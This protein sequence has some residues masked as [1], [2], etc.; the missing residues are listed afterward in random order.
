M[1]SL[2]WFF[3]ADIWYSIKIFILDFIWRLLITSQL[4]VIY[5]F[6]KT[7]GLFQWLSGNQ[8]F[9]IIFTENQNNFNR[10]D[11]FYFNRENLPLIFI[12]FCIVAFTLTSII[13]IIHLIIIQFSEGGSFRQKLAISIKNSV[14]AFILIIFIPIFFWFLN[15]FTFLLADLVNKIS[16]FNK[17]QNVSI[18]QILYSVGAYKRVNLWNWTTEFEP[19]EDIENWNLLIQFFACL[20]FLIVCFYLALALVQRLFE[21]FFLFLISP[22]IISMI[23]IDN[24]RRFFIW[25]DL[26]IAKFISSFITNLTFVVFLNIL[27][28]LFFSLPDKIGD[29][30]FRQIIIFIFLVGCSFSAIR[31]QN[32]SSQLLGNTSGLGEGKRMIGN[33]F[34]KTMYFRR[35]F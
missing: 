23:P 25:K 31:I 30:F 21:L 4:K 1:V 12:I 32:L 24:Y 26:V 7:D 8:I 10:N 14:S 11:L 28:K 34:S 15:F 35:R 20:F 19:P 27:P 6:M 29:W 5:N 13:F 3:F 16:T 22:F 9:K 2:I 18:I 33:L 17:K